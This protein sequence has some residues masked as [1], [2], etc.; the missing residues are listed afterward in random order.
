MRSR[1]R[2]VWNG[3]TPNHTYYTNALLLLLYI[4]HLMLNK[5]KKNDFEYG[6]RRALY[7]IL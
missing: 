2:H 5:K 6:I 7:M 3:P 1:M 4:I